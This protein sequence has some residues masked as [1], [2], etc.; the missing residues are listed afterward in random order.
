MVL[1]FIVGFNDQTGKDVTRT[2][3]VCC[4]KSIALNAHSTTPPP[5]PSLQKPK[6]TNL[7]QGPRV[8]GGRSAAKKATSGLLTWCKMYTNGFE[9]VKVK[10][11]TSSWQDGWV[12]ERSCCVACCVVG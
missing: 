8:G 5:P 3:G 4:S 12:V 9:G 1:S 11:F 6:R 10:D 7:R 2:V